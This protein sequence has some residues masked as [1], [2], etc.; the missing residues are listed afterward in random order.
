MSLERAIYMLKV[1]YEKAFSNKIIRKPIAY[2][3]FQVWKYADKH[4]K[5]R[6]YE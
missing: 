1:A 2:A 3:L 6:A 5:E 4:E